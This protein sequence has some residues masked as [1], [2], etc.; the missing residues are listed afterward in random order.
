MIEDN[1]KNNYLLSF[2]LHVLLFYI[3]RFSKLNE[4]ERIK[5]NRNY[6]F[7]I[8]SNFFFYFILSRMLDYNQYNI[9]A[10]IKKTVNN[11]LYAKEIS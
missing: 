6:Y 9:N 1:N 10:P 4:D 11:Q 8:K 3:N 7:L 2:K 5:N